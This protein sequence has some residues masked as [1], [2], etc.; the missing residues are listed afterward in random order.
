MAA[1]APFSSEAAGSPDLVGEADLEPPDP[2]L[3]FRNALSRYRTARLEAM[4]GLRGLESEAARTSTMASALCGQLD[5]P[6]VVAAVLAGLNASSRQ[7][8]GLFAL[9]EASVWP[10]DGL[11]HAL[12][13]LG[14]DPRSTFVDLL[15]KGLLALEGTQDQ[16]PID[17]FPRWI[18][19]GQAASVLVRAHPSVSH[20][21]RI[22][23]PE[24][25]LAPVSGPV[26]QIRDPDG[27]EPII[28]LAALWQRV[29]VEPLRQTQQAALYKRDLE[30]IEDDP[31]LSGAII[32]ALEPLPAMPTFWLGLARRVGLIHRSATGDRL[33]ATGPEF[34]TDN[35]VH[36]PQMIVASWLGLRTWR[37]WGAAP[38][39][40]V[41]A[42]VPLAFLR[43]VLLLWL[44]CL[45][46]SQWVALDDLAEHLQAHNPEWDRTSFRPE[47]QI[48]VPKGRGTFAG[49]KAG[50]HAPRRSRG[51][52]VLRALLLGAGSALGVIR[53]GKEEGSGRIVVQLTSLGRYVLAMGPPPQP[54]LDYQHFL[55]V[56]PNLEIIAYRQGLNPLLV[57]RLSR[58][59]WWT[60]I[61]A[62][63][64]LKLTQESVVLG[65][66]GGGT[67]DQMIETLTR[68]SQ[69]PLPSLVPDAIGRWAR[70]RERITIYMAATLIEF[71]SPEDRNSALSSWDENDARAF[72]PVAER[73]LLVENPQQIPTD[74]IRTSG[75]RDYRHPPEK[76]VSIEPDGV[77]LELDLTRSDLLIDAELA[78]IADELP[79]A[80]AAARNA[81]GGSGLPVRKY[82]VSASSMARAAAIGITP[83]QLSE[84]FLRRTGEPPSPAIRLLF[85][86]FSAT[87]TSLLARQMLVLTTPSEELADGL[88]QHPATR[89]LLGA[90]LGPTAVAIAD[91]G[92]EALRTVLSELGISLEVQRS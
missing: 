8:L 92:L 88:L 72:V 28:R 35:A 16:Q 64:E 61:G 69:R 11:R 34:W 51:D 83:G 1:S 54:R 38:G 73:F 55:F 7:A 48:S 81:A 5:S 63:L 47:T 29:A 82:L 67:P 27:L 25:T 40:P 44:A 80:L 22:T 33:E 56:Q 58:F 10:M 57:G 36:L 6:S 75:S 78:R 62:A 85:R 52:R 32:D 71:G 23:R 60:K 74:R 70:H 9:A 3:A 30:R 76:C 4:A 37:E 31:V 59:A 39:E 50:S 68:H 21:V 89:D 19:P 2:R 46:E 20:G 41:D 87:P 53:S 49:G 42:G 18:E 14:S 13:T 15:E 84:W 43:P 86:L 91:N 90:R 79:P 12:A 26:S 66:E 45:E 17:D 65:L 77:T 24:G